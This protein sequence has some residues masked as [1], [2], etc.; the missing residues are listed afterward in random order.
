MLHPAA[1]LRALR[2]PGRVVLVDEAFADAVPGEAESVAGE[3]GFLVFRSL[4]KTWA[5]AVEDEATFLDAE[6]SPVFFG[7]V[8][9]IVDRTG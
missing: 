1:A 3:P 4:T 2:S 6:A 9:V 8:H 5:L 7:R